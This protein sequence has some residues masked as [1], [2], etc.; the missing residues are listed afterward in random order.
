[1]QRTCPSILGGARGEGEGGCG[2]GKDGR[3]TARVFEPCHPSALALLW[4]VTSVLVSHRSLIQGNAEKG[5]VGLFIS[6]KDRN[7]GRNGS[8]VP[9]AVPSGCCEGS[10]VQE[11][12]LAL[13]STCEVVWKIGKNKSSTRQGS[14]WLLV[15]VQKAI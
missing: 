8:A 4:D 11:F 6:P 5:F 3:A 1:M 7:Q 12:T 15:S 13:V 10:N 9:H 2:E 14:D